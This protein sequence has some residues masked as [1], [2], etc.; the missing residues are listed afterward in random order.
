MV[1]DAAPAPADAV[2]PL[3]MIRSRRFVVL[4]LLAGIVGIVVSVAAWAFLEAV[5][6]TQRGVYQDLP[7]ALGFDGVPVWWPLPVLII[8]GVIAGC[9]IQFLPGRGGHIPASSVT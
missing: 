2:D 3:E 9:A 7:D 4:L 1:D 5:Y 6:W 8:A